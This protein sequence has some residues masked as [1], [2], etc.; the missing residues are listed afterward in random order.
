MLVPNFTELA[1]KRIAEMI[2]GNPAFTVYLPE[3]NWDRKALNRQYLYNVS[4]SL[5]LTSNL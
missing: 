1:A 5:L 3:L 4:R 2:T